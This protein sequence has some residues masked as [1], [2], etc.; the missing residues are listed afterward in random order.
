MKS[1]T[2]K[3]KKRFNILEEIRIAEMGA[4][5]MLSFLAVSFIKLSG[6]W[7]I[8]GAV[9]GAAGTSANASLMGVVGG[10]L[11]FSIIAMVYIILIKNIKDRKD[12][13]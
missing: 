10:A 1:S 8:T 4:V 7:G 13:K 9:V 5:L 6:E 3:A 12:K 2:T 11:L